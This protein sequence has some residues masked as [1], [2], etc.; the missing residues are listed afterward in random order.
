MR[1]EQIT[2]AL[3]VLLANCGA[4]H[5]QDVQQIVRQAV[6]T[7][8]KADAADHTRWIFYDVDNK[9]NAKVKQWVAQT[10]EGDM[11]RVVQQ[12]G[13]PLNAAQQRRTM[14]NFWHDKRA[15]AKQI[16][17]N[18][19]DQQQAEQMLKLL[20][21]AFVWSKTGEQ[22]GCYLL[23]F[24][25]DPHFHPQSYE[26]RVFA[27]AEGEMAVEESNHRIVS[28]KGRLM[29]N[30]QFGGGLLGDLKAGGTFDVER[31][32]IG[33]G[34]WQITETHVHINGRALLFKSIADEEDDVKSKFKQIASNLSLADT[35]KMLTAQ[36]N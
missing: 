19:H 21:V 26:A 1:R 29:H 33:S 36:N 10:A 8:L 12:N 4:A 16:K 28:L 22:S 27:A 32:D 20:P 35:E 13:Q 24:A 34:E 31:R 11:H 25:P 15:Q 23:H 18:R 6:E 3:S 9:P 5:G 7:E 17:S 14:N 30:V 2:L